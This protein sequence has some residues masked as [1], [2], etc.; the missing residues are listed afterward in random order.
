MLSLASCSCPLRFTISQLHIPADT[1]E[2]CGIGRTGFLFQY[3]G[4]VCAPR[5]PRCPRYLVEHIA[6]VLLADM[7]DNDDRKG[8]PVGKLLNLGNIPVI[9]GIG[10]VL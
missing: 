9:T 7:V 2:P 3:K 5:Q 4:G 1:V 10:V 8:M 6:V